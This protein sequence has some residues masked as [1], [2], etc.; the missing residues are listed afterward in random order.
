M[1]HDPRNGT[2]MWNVILADDNVDYLLLLL[3]VSSSMLLNP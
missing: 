1:W 2:I 3:E